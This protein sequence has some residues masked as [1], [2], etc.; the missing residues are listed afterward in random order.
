M[1][2]FNENVHHCNHYGT[3]TCASYYIFQLQKKRQ[4]P[5]RCINFFTAA[6]SLP[7][8]GTNSQSTAIL[9]PIKKIVLERVRTIKQFKRL[10]SLVKE[11][12][13]TQ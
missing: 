5:S 4:D 10:V 13:K 12:F 9:I 8:I 6:K 1:N 7:T 2:M 11:R 3:E